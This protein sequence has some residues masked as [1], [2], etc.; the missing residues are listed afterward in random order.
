MNYNSELVGN[1]FLLQV[2]SVACMFDLSHATPMPCSLSFNFECYLT[3]VFF[4]L[5]VYIFLLSV[6]LVFLLFRKSLFTR[7]TVMNTEM[8][9]V[10]QPS[11]AFPYML[12]K[13]ETAPY[14][15]AVI[16][17]KSRSVW[18]VLEFHCHLISHVNQSLIFDLLP[19]GEK[20]PDSTQSVSVIVE[21]GGNVFSALV[22]MLLKLQMEIFMSETA[23]VKFMFKGRH[24]SSSSWRCSVRDFFE[25]SA[26]AS[27]EGKHNLA[28]VE[29]A[30][31][32]PRAD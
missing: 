2:S 8:H 16:K 11:N 3:G 32:K 7:I 1:S 6:S 24:I 9:C 31:R 22:S 19:A 21:D 29:R 10:R 4:I 18:D 26:P 13:G 5:F 12:F 25:E 30:H 28:L 17:K 20:E 27:D 15:L 14:L 23:V